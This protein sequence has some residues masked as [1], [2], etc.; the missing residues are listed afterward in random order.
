MFKKI[1]NDEAGV[2]PIVATLVL[3]VVA[4]AGA[5]AVGTILGSFSG[6]VS[7]QASAGDAAGSASMELVIAGSST[8]QPVS[9]LLA[10]AYMDKNP[11]VKVTV[12]GGGSGAGITGAKMGYVDIGAAS[13]DVDTVNDYPELQKFTIGGSGVVVIVNDNSGGLTGAVVTAAN[14]SDIYT[15]ANGDGTAGLTV[16]GGYLTESAAATN[17]TI[18]DRADKS[19]TEET[20]AKFI[21]GGAEKSIDA[22]ASGVDGGEGNQGVLEKVQDTPDSL[23]FVD[24][25]FADGASGVTIL[26]LE[27]DGTSYD[28]NGDGDTIIL[29]TLQGTQDYPLKRPLNYLT[30]GNPSSLQKS[31]IDFAL[32]PGSKDI[33]HETGYYAAVEFM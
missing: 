1:F 7:E 23:G 4:I 30:N 6:D 10:E 31:F 18:F 8:V 21:T 14:L 12:Q 9:E 33:Y 25:G 29:E 5:A 19:G 2:S 3:V 32:S 28:V 11:G 17:Y 22:I 16:T 15:A 13:K 24:Y 27:H 20:F 26:N